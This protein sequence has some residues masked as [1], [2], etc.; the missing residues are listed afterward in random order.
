[1]KKTP[2]NGEIIF[3]SGKQSTP[4]Q[5]DDVL[6]NELT[7]EIEAERAAAN[8]GTADEIRH[9]SWLKKWQQRSE[10]RNKRHKE[11]RTVMSGG[12]L[13]NLNRL[14]SAEFALLGTDEE[15][16]AFILKIEQEWKEAK[17]REIRGGGS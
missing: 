5:L 8:Q 14:Q 10:E 11:I 12:I 16:R 13:L 2:M 1:M 17:I 7:Q 6:Q 9:V 15:K 3:D 4:A